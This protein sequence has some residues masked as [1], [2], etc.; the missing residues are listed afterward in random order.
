MKGSQ[1]VVNS[2]LT[3]AAR[4]APE[5]LRAGQDVAVLTELHECPTWL[6][7]GEL[8]GVRPEET[9]RLQVMSRCGGLPLRIKAVCL[10]FLVVVR[11]DGTAVS[12]DVRRVQLVKLDRAYAKLVRKLLREKPNS[13]ACDD[14]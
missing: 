7:S 12:L 4:L 13:A 5:E 10:P 14:E 1:T 2:E 9:V 8:V 3:V 11:P 6:W